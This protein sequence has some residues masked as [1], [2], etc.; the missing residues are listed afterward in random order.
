MADSYAS[1]NVVHVVKSPLNGCNCSFGSLAEAVVDG[2][3][4]AT[5]ATALVPDAAAGVIEVEL[6]LLSIF[7]IDA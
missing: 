1:Q 7:T 6:E 2:V 4:L 3:A 5:D